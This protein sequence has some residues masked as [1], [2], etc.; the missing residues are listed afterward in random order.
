MCRKGGRSCGFDDTNPRAARQILAGKPER[1]TSAHRLE[2]D[3]T[4]F[5][6]TSHLAGRA[7]QMN[8]HLVAFGDKVRGHRLPRDALRVHAVAVS[9]VA[10]ALRR[11][12]R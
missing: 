3:T 5:A 11:R 4:E 8:E 2:A 6:G 1:G 10:A 9:A 12:R 7:A